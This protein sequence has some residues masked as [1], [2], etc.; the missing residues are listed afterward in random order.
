MQL[1]SHLAQV[2]EQLLAAAALGDDR[3]REIAGVLGTAADPA[4]RLA[5]VNAVGE[6]AAEITAALLDYPGSPAVSVRLD[7]NE[8][9]VDV[10]SVAAPVDDEAP[11]RD[12]G[13]PNARISLR[14]TDALKADID[15]AA[16]RDGVSV[17]TWLVRA[18]SA[19]LRAGVFA[20]GSGSFSSG[21]DT[22]P[23]FGGRGRRRD[24]QHRITGWI[25]G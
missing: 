17:N 18:A 24:N 12:G 11:R 21:P 15:A 3:A 10:H 8:I 20:A 16:E 23:A 6:A 5:L 25:N 4:V 22:G 7:G 13:D 14:L 19:A 2:H 1:E 9:A